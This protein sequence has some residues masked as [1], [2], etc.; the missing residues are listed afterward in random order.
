MNMMNFIDM[1]DLI[2]CDEELVCRSQWI[3]KWSYSREKMKI[4]RMMMICLSTLFRC[5]IG[6]FMD[7]L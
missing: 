2:G 3:K 7:Y 4:I 5:K 1:T 6:Y